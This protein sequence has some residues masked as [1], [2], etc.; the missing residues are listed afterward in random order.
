MSVIMTLELTGDAKGL[1]QF[2]EENRDKMQA[3][4]KAAKQHGLIAHRFY[5]SDD[6][7]RL[8]VLDEWP[9]R[10]S[11]ESFFREQ[12]SEIRPMMEAAGATA[13][14]QASFWNQLATHDE[15]GWGA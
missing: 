10:Q 8:M 12:E 15:F 3:V 6:G 13:E 4:L 2:A 5:G 9:D 14:P 1:E 7:G 11:F